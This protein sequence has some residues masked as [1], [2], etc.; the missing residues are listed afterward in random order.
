MPRAPLSAEQKKINLEKMKAGK[1][2]KANAR[3]EAKAKGLP[4]PHPRKPRKSKKGTE[5]V[6][7]LKNPEALPAV[8]DTIRQIDSTKPENKTAMLPTEAIP[9]KS[10]LIDVPHLPEHLDVIVKKPLIKPSKVPKVKENLDINN[11]I[12]N[13]ETG[14][15]VIST[16]L[17]GQEESI[18]MVLKENKKKVK[19][20][21]PKANPD[22]PTQTVSN[23][24]KHVPDIKSI[25][26]GEPFS[27][28]AM[29]KKL[30]Q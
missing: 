1:A 8:N 16:M 30:Y 10:T 20:I 22:P 9:A 23:I 17:P 2:K 26:G 3:A 15:Q 24:A 6:L 27:F 25:Q 19:P 18:K 21:V 13:K 14:S 12:V 7:A 29:R 11:I 4:D 28:S 5:G